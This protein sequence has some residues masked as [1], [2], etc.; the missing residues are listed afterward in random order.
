MARIIEGRKT[1][2]NHEDIVVF[3]IGARINKWWLLPLALP[4]LSKMRAMQK[5]LLADPDSGLL[6]IQSLGLADVQYWRSAEH[7]MRYANDRTREHKP[8]AR[9]YYQKLFRNE[10][11]GIWHET[12]LVPAGQ[13]ECIYT[14]MPQTGLGK[15]RPLVEAK[16]PLQSAPARLQAH[17]TLGEAP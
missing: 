5:E 10:A 13:Y 9:R 4:I 12:Y 16:G 3:L 11:V 15:L 14:N 17:A 7:L 6:A 1:V 2:R 8:A